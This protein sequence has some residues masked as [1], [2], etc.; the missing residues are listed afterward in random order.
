MRKMRRLLVRLGVFLSRLDWY[1]WRNYWCEPNMT[2]RRFVILLLLLT[3]IPF[4]GV[5]VFLVVAGYA[6]VNGL[7]RLFGFRR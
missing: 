3:A 6:L 7:D 2:S 1:G 5:F 4:V